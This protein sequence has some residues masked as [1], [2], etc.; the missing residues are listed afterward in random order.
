[1]AYTYLYD[2]RILKVWN[3]FVQS[4]LYKYKHIKLY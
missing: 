2:K 3:D 1:M 4:K